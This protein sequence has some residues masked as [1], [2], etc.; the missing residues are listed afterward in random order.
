[1]T[2]PSSDSNLLS[3][4]DPGHTIEKA[5]PTKKNDSTLSLAETARSSK[6]DEID[7][8]NAKLANPLAGLSH[9]QLMEDGKAFATRYGLEDLSE[10]FK[11]GALVAKDPL[12][13]EDLSLLTEE[14]KQA[15]REEVS[16]KWKQPK[17]LYYLVILCSGKSSMD[18]SVINGAN[19]FFAP[20]FGIEPRGGTAEQNSRNQWILGLVNSAPYLCCAV[21]GC[22]LTGPL[23][24]MFGR[25]GTIFITAFFSFITCIWQGVTN[26][27]PH[28]FVARFILGLGIGP[29]SSTVPVYVAECA[30][31]SIRGALVMMWQTW[32]AF[33]IMLGF[34]MDLA[35]F[36][37]PNTTHITGLNWRLM[38]G[39]AGVPA[40]FIVVQVFF[41][42]ES[43]RWLLSKGRYRDAYESLCSVRMHPIQAARDLYYMNV[44]LEAENEMQ[45][46][47]SRFFELFTVPRNRRATLASFIVMFICGVNVI[48]YYSSEIF[49]DAHFSQI[50]AL[51]ASFGFGAINFVFAFPAVYTIDTFGRRNLLLTTF[52]LMALF[53]LMTG[54]SFWIP[55]SSQARL[56][57]ISLGIYL[58]GMAYSP[59]EGPVP[60]TYSAEA[61]PLYVRDIGMSLATAT[62][63][64]FNFIIAITFPRLLGAF[65]P[66]GAFGWYA[67]WNMLGFLAVLL[68]VPET[69]ALSLEELDQVFS[70]PTRVHA[71]YQVKALPRN[72]KKYIFRMN[73]PDV[74]PLYEHERAM[75]G[76]STDAKTS[77]KTV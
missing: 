10:L 52:P 46:H 15:L 31:P 24:R 44:L 54:F 64:F 65:K 6:K 26:S 20:Q 12:A 14:E 72:I 76:M 73:V 1:M 2:L 49:A 4:N 69:K 33:G 41:V 39:S 53:L 61:F 7:F 34:V 3:T 68:F 47:G 58:F 57:M 77:M 27:W 45:R 21:L 40:L 63:W 59:G 32:T 67:G 75:Q 43:P 60:F 25:R 18:E 50:Q 5:S 38:L 62:L 51:L 29:K 66:Q 55:E 28:L 70:V 13:F 23:N 9:E 36:K 35:F 37:V 22:W 19:L 30:P 56:A 48:A 8:L 17:M 71:A 11:K 42:P 16:N 74:P